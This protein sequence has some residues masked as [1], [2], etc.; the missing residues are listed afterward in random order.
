MPPNATPSRS[1]NLT[2][3]FKSQTYKIH[4]HRAPK[5]TASLFSLV[6]KHSRDD[7]L[8]KSKKAESLI[9]R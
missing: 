6:I 2:S 4:I 8:K 5:K 3:M 1:Q 7:V 9:P